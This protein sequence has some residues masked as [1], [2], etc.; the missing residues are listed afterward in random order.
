M[1][2][3][4]RPLVPRLSLDGVNGCLQGFGIARAPSLLEIFVTQPPLKHPA[5]H[6]VGFAVAADSNVGKGVVIWRWR[7][8]KHRIVGDPDQYVGLFW[9]ASFL[10]VSTTFIIIIISCVFLA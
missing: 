2:M 5:T 1:N 7:M 8:K 4:L 6:P 10:A 3:L 9:F